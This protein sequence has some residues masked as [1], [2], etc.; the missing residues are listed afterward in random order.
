MSVQKKKSSLFGRV[1]KDLL[2][3][4]FT[5]ILMNACMSMILLMIVSNKIENE[6]LT[7]SGM[8]I[9]GAVMGLVALGY[10]GVFLYMVGGNQYEML[11]SGN[12]KR[13]SSTQLTM[14]KYVEEKEFRFYKGFLYGFVVSIP[15]IVSGIL[16]GA[17]PERTSL[18]MLILE[19][20]AGWAGLP[21]YYTNTQKLFPPVNGYLSL[22]YALLPIVVSGVFYIVGGYAR[23]NKT[24]RAQEEQLRKI[25]EINSKPKKI[26]YGGLPGTK[27]RKKK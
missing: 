1:I 11:V 18:G 21:F 3:N 4:S 6:T 10:N 2:A 7:Q 8:F 5:P 17:R 26:N 19:L 14:N 23:R 22:L 13:S 12:M 24:L 27:P 25:E 20:L 16:L 15:L 9:W